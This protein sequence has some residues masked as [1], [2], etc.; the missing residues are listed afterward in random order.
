MTDKANTSSNSSNKKDQ[1]KWSLGNFFRRKK[2]DAESDSTSEDE[3]KVCIQKRKKDKRTRKLGDAFDHIV[4]PSNCS[5]QA[6]IDSINNSD[7]YLLSATNS[8]SLDRRLRRER[9]RQVQTD[10]NHSSSEEDLHN[11]SRFR[12]DDSLGNHS[13]G[14]N[15]RKSRSARTERYMRRISRDGSQESPIEVHQPNRWQTQP[16][17]SSTLN[18]SIQSFDNSIS[19]YKPSQQY[20][21]QPLRNSSSLNQVSVRQ[22]S[23]SLPFSYENQQGISPQAFQNVESTPPPPLPPKEVN[24]NNNKKYVTNTRPV[25]YSF[26]QYPNIWSVNNRCSSDDRLWGYNS[27]HLSHDQ[28]QPLQNRPSSVQPETQP[29]RFIKRHQQNEPPLSNTQPTS[30]GFHYITDASPRSRRPI[31]VMEKDPRQIMN[32]VTLGPPKPARTFQERPRIMVAQSLQSAFVAT[33]PVPEQIVTET[34]AKRCGVKAATEFWKKIEQ[35]NN[36]TP[37]RGRSIEPNR[38]QNGFK[39]RS[40]SSSRAL[41]LMNKRN[42]ELDKKLE[43]VLRNEEIMNHDEVDGIVNGRLCLGKAETPYSKYHIH[44]EPKA[45]I[46]HTNNKFYSLPHSAHHHHHHYLQM[47]H[48]SSSPPKSQSN[49]RCQSEDNNAIHVQL[50]AEPQQ[51]VRIINQPPPIPQRSS[52]KRRSWHEEEKFKNRRSRNLEEAISELETIYKSLKLSDEELL[53]RAEQRETS[54]ISAFE[55]YAQ[56]YRDDDDDENKKEPDVIKDDLL[57]RSLKHANNSIKIHDHQPP[58]GIPIGPIPPPPNSDYLTPEARKDKRI[59]SQQTPDLVGDDLAVR[60]LRKDKDLPKKEQKYEFQIVK[61]SSEERKLAAKSLSENIF[62]MIQRDSTKPS[63]GT[64]D[65]YMKIDLKAVNNNAKKEDTKQETSKDLFVVNSKINGTECKLELTPTSSKKAN[66]TSKRYCSE[67]GAVFNL[68]TALKT[69]P[70]VSP[71]P[72]MSELKGLKPKPL[73]RKSV[74]PAELTTEEKHDF[75][76]ILNQIA[77]EAKATSEKIGQDLIELQKGTK[78]M[79]KSPNNTRKNLKG[80]QIERKASASPKPQR[81]ESLQELN[82]EVSV[83]SKAAKIC[84]EMMMNVAKDR[85]KIKCSKA[86]KERLIADVQ[87]TAKAAKVCEEIISDIVSD[88]TS[89]TPSPKAS[90]P[91]SEHVKSLERLSKG[92]SNG[93]SAFVPVKS[94][95]IEKLEKQLIAKITPKQITE[96]KESPEKK[97]TPPLKLKEKIDIF[98][99]VIKPTR[100]SSSS[101]KTVVLNLTSSKKSSPKLVESDNHDYD[102]LVK[103]SISKIITRQNGSPDYENLKKTPVKE[104]S[105]HT[106]FFKP[107][108]VSNSP[109]FSHQHSR[110]EEIDKIMKE[111]ETMKMQDNR[112]NVLPTIPLID[113]MLEDSKNDAPLDINGSTSKTSSSLDLSEYKSSAYAT[114]VE[115]IESNNNI[116]T[117]Q[118]IMSNDAQKNVDDDLPTIQLKKLSSV[119]TPTSLTLVSPLIISSSSTKKSDDIESIYNSSEELAAIFGIDSSNSSGASTTG[120]ALRNA[121][122]KC[123]LGLKSSTN[124]SSDSSHEAFVTESDVTNVQSSATYKTTQ[125]E[126]C[127]TTVRGNN[128]NNLLLDTILESHDEELCEND[129]LNNTSNNIKFNRNNTENLNASNASLLCSLE[130][131]N[132]NNNNQNNSRGKINNSNNDEDEGDDAEIESNTDDSGNVS[133]NDFCYEYDVGNSSVTKKA[134]FVNQIEIEQSNDKYPHKTE[135]KIESISDPELSDMECDEVDGQATNI[136][137]ASDETLVE[138]EINNNIENQNNHNILKERR[139]HNRVSETNTI[140]SN[141]STSTSKTNQNTKKS[142]IT[143]K[144][145]TIIEPQ[146]L[147]LACTYGMANQDYLTFLAIIIAIITLFALLML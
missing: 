24:S 97:R 7:K 46:V 5:V 56:H 133:L 68:P 17:I 15:S 105:S 75:E 60:N 8:G 83:V 19:Q 100:D 95:K 89:T 108:I 6:N 93:K 59:L 30:G 43:E 134:I 61:R 27:M 20:M 120:K 118:T 32:T 121:R 119:T 117:L 144:T 124:S 142:E 39:P 130:S 123:S 52:S 76:N 29:R 127:I 42:E 129:A 55:K 98:E 34:E 12:S 141:P 57:Y 106:K 71:P 128:N 115:M 11:I 64:L 135:I 146:H 81:R 104:I 28:A 110:E 78:S 18:G 145:H 125:W 91:V 54:N 65:D 40:V 87:A 112:K 38:I 131:H 26:D 4:V 70:S 35:E 147:L 22:Q 73:P 109:L 137:T 41:E 16:I 122:L 49:N 77:D 88:T 82:N 86:D 84:E 33:K 44:V 111:C 79:S 116:E 132:Q 23:Y 103:T 47:T 10:H 3:K 107:D 45:E 31:H 90:T 66:I 9:L 74:S 114:P 50:T 2:K 58:F 69:S 1:R 143:K 25:S 92:S 85:K 139:Q 99:A 140:K 102:N 36:S 67:K 21:H 101:E 136:T 138:H 13:N 96:R 53:D 48:V 37:Q 126:S 63:G 72:P 14:S 113:E 94:N 62:A 51:P 80:K